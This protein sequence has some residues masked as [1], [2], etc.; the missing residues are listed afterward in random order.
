VI[1]ADKQG[2]MEAI[3]TSL[4]KFNET[5]RLVNII[6]SGTGEINESDIKLA[7][8][9]KAIVVG[10]NTKI[11]SQASRMAEN[12]HVLVRT[13]N[14]IYELLDEMEEVIEGMIR[15]G[16]IEETLGKA[17]IIAEFSGSSGRV[18][19]CRVTEG[20]FTRNL[21]IKV[22]REGEVIG[23]GKV[24][25]LRKVKDEVNK[26]EKGND[27]GMIFDPVIDFQV[28]DVVESFRII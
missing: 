8:S 17:N 18:A 7:A 14:I 21:K 13:Y 4:L 15:P 6:S 19:G 2:S 11:S 12:E 28:G 5:E 22:T 16:E 1:K 20:Y 9:V 27:C 24:G 23:E 3:E 25:T 10:F 26:V